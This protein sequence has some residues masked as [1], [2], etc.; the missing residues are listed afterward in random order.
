MWKR[1]NKVLSTSEGRLFI[2]LSIFYSIY[3]FIR[4]GINIY[5]RLFINYFNAPIAITDSLKVW[6]IEYFTTLM[7][8][9]S[10]ILFTRKQFQRK[11]SWI[12]IIVFNFFYSVVLT[13]FI[14]ILYNLGGYWFIERSFENPLD[15]FQNILIN[16]PF[17]FL[18][19]LCFNFIILAYYYLEESKSTQIAKNALENELNISKFKILSSQ[20]QPHFL[21]NSINSVIN[22]ID[23][24]KRKA[25]DSLVDLCDF[26]RNVLEVGDDQTILL[27]REVFILEKYVA[28]MKTRFDDKLIYINN[29]E[30]DCLNCKLPSLLLQPIVENALKYG[31]SR[32][33]KVL[34][35]EVAAT[36]TDDSLELKIMN[37]GRHIDD[38][39]EI[40]SRGTGMS[41]LKKRLDHLYDYNYTLEIKN[42]LSPNQVVFHFILPLNER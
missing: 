25:Q 11:Y 33:H 21:F 22:L 31:Y 30:P 23:E 10:L 18:L 20:V 9:G 4:I 24:D 38:I 1:T 42:N 28:M 37:N 27:E 15:Y 3:F 5:A 41:N 17:Y 29:I 34:K 40:Y 7:V 13:F 39:E 2:F 36:K 8:A 26:F 12:R 32:E 19:V 14:I 6:A 35:I 16:F